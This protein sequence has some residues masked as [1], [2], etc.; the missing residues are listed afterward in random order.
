MPNLEKLE[1]I[2]RPEQRAGRET[3][4]AARNLENQH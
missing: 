3:S 4:G 1:I 2:N